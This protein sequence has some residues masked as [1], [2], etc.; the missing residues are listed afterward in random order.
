MIRSIW[1]NPLLVGDSGFRLVGV[2]DSAARSARAKSFGIMIGKDTSPVLRPGW[3]VAAG[4]LLLFTGCLLIGQAGVGLKRGELPAFSR[5]RPGPVN[6][7][8]SADRFWQ[9]EVLYS[10]FGLMLAGLGVWVLKDGFMKRPH[11]EPN[12]PAA[13]DGGITSQPAAESARPATT[14]QER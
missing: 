5:F 4:G 3:A 2:P 12:P 7:N 9:S 1:P 8:E 10:G 6:R 13:L 14:E 11:A